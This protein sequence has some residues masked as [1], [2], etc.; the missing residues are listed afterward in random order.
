M[1]LDVK[2]ELLTNVLNLWKCQMLPNNVCNLWKFLWNFKLK[3]T[4]NLWK[5]QIDLWKI[6]TKCLEFMEIEEKKEPKCLGINGSCREEKGLVNKGKE[7]FNNIEE[8]V[9]IRNVATLR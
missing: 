1:V 7:N 6:K 3:C 4:L 5:Y 9:I 8:V 2:I